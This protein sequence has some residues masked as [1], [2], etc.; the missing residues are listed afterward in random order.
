VA[1]CGDRDAL[2]NLNTPEE[3]TAALAADASPIEEVRGSAPSS[4]VIP[5]G[6]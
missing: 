1:D 2:L 6:G 5:S 4:S 3:Y